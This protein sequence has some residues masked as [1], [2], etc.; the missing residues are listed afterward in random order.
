MSLPG[1]V[2]ES[3][4]TISGGAA[5]LSAPQRATPD[6]KTTLPVLFDCLVYTYEYSY[7]RQQGIPLVVNGNPSQ[8]ELSRQASPPSGWPCM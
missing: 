1:P 3:P 2:T 5:D 6:T 4:L 7:L 8:L